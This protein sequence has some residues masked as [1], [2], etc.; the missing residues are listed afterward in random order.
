MSTSTGSLSMTILNNSLF[1][2]E[3]LLL[4]MQIFRE[5]K[6]SQQLL[7]LKSSPPLTTLKDLRRFLEPVI[8]LNKFWLEKT[9]F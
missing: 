9:K 1:K 3:S 8:Q 6:E 2:T 4:N 7:V 5:S